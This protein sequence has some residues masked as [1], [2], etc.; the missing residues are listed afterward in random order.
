MKKLKFKIHWSFVLLG[1]GLFAF[2]KIYIFFC[3]ILAVVLHELGHFLVAKKLGYSLNLITLMPYGASLSGESEIIN[4]KHEILIAI[5]GPIVNVLL[6]LLCIFLK[7][8]CFF[9]LNIFLNANISTF[10]FNILPVFPLD[11]GRVLLAL[12]STKHSRVKAQKIVG[13]IGYIVCFSFVV[14]FII[15]Y[16]YNLNYMLGI[17][18]LFLLISLLDENKNAYYS[19]IVNF[20]LTKEKKWCKKYKIDSNKTILDTYKLTN[21]SSFCNILIIDKN[22]KVR[23]II[24]NNDIKKLLFESKYNI[25]LKEAFCE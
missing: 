7:K 13:F 15:S 16:F 4:P 10:L 6:A 2:G 14:M 12:V 25:S 20:N 22:K 19:S 17:N 23:K 3:Y 21:N 24:S 9:N 8:V 18:S 11:G 5:S 1:V